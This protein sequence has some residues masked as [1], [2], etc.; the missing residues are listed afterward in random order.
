MLA[1]QWLPRLPFD[2]ADLLIIDEIGKNISGSGM[3]TNVVGRK[4]N[5]HKAADDESPR[6]SGS[7]SAA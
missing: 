6:S 1:K 2:Q 5:D 3:D 4:F 7:S